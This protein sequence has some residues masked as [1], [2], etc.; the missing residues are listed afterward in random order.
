MTRLKR[1]AGETNR[2]EDIED[3]LINNHVSF[4]YRECV[5]PKQFDAEKSL[6]NQAR[7]GSPLNEATVAT[8]REAVENDEL[9]PPLLVEKQGDKYVVLDGNHRL[10]AHA[11]AGASV[12]I[13][14][15]EGT[16]QQLAMLMF[17]ANAKHG[18][19]SSPE[20]RLHH[21]LYIVDNG[22]T[23]ADACR[24]LGVPRK[25]LT[26]A[27]AKQNASRR[28]DDAGIRRPDWESIPA[29]A[30]TRLNAIHT[31]EG[32]RAATDLARKAGLGTDEV[33]KM[34]ARMNETRNA[35]RQVGVVNALKVEYADRIASAAVNGATKPGK[36]ANV[37]PRTRLASVLGMMVTLP[38]ASAYEHLDV[39][40]DVVDEL[41][42]KVDEAADYL[43]ELRGVLA[44]VPA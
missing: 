27:I 5:S 43:K 37:S 34:V 21:A 13:Y 40:E 22:I 23:Q 30:R 35:S 9:F 2:R 26:K 44:G 39:P 7:I 24:L 6:R 4:T 42:K 20:D 12:D 18:L 25:D 38:P 10:R 33:F 15:C 17:L 28:A 14:I 31:D 41:V 29:S 8:Y 36:R 1:R 3:F 11:Q 19:P 32:F 16:R